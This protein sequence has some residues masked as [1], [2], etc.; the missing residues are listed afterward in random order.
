MLH[1]NVWMWGVCTI[2]TF[3]VQAFLFKCLGVIMRKATQ[4]QFVQKLLDTVF[5][6]VKHS[7]QVEREVLDINI[8]VHALTDVKCSKSVKYQNT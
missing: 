4:R 2:E 7:N 1:C 8:T 6:A 3:C 5:S